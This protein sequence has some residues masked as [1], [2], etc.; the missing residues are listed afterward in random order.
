MLNP[1]YIEPLL[2]L[3]KTRK[4]TKSKPNNHS[5]LKIRTTNEIEIKIETLIFS[6][7]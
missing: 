5:F 2:L 6:T 3:K 7:C 4:C 1:Y